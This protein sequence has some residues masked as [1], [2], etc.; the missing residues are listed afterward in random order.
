MAQTRNEIEVFISNA[1]AVSREIQLFDELFVGGGKDAAHTAMPE[2]LKLLHASLFRS[3]VLG[4]CSFFDPAASRGD[5]NLSIKYLKQSLGANLSEE[6]SKEMEAAQAIYEGLGIDAYRNKYLAHYDFLH[7]VGVKT[8]KHSLTSEELNK[9]MLSLIRIG[10]S[11]DDD[12]RGVSAE[13]LFAAS[14]LRGADSGQALLAV[15]AAIN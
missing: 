6:T 8:T 10:L 1:V 15:V 4:V 9:L 3:I 7:F 14:R 5:K 13:E 11:I 2:T 12:G